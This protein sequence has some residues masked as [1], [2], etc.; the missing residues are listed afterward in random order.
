MLHELIGEIIAASQVPRQLRATLHLDLDTCLVLQILG[1]HPSCWAL[2]PSDCAEMATFGDPPRSLETT[3]WRLSTTDL[4]PG[5]WVHG[6]LA[7]LTRTEKSS[8]GSSFHPGGVPAATSYP[9]NSSEGALTCCASREPLGKT[10]SRR[11]NTNH[12][13]GVDAKLHLMMLWK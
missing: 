4:F 8:V 12:I 7:E 2:M 9:S 13:K 10:A 11:M 3:E 5:P 1:N 6:G